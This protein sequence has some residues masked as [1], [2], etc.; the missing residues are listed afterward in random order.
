MGR[1]ASGGGG[2][3]DHIQLDNREVAEQHPTGAITNLDTQLAVIDTKLDKITGFEDRDS[4]RLEF[5]FVTGQ[6]DVVPNNGSFVIWVD[7]TRIEF[8]ET[9]SMVVPKTDLIRT[10]FFDTGGILQST[11]ESVDNESAIQNNTVVC[12]V[13]CNVEDGLYNQ[14]F[15]LRYS[16]T[17][18]QSTRRNFASHHGTHYQTGFEIQ[19]IIADGDGS[20]DTHAQF[21]V[22]DGVVNL[23]DI[24]H[25]SSQS[26]QVLTS[27]AQIL[28]LYYEGTSWKAK[29]IDDFP[30]IYEG[31]VG[32][33][34]GVLMPY[35]TRDIL[36]QGELL[37]PE[38]GAMI[39]VHYFGTTGLDNS[40]IAVMGIREYYN[41]NDA[42][43]GGQNE[44]QM[45]LSVPYFFTYITPIGS[46]VYQTSN[47]Y[48]NTPHARIISTYD[49]ST[50]TDTRKHKE[51]IAGSNS[52]VPS[53][54]DDKFHVYDAATNLTMKMNLENLNQQINSTVSWSPSE[55]DIDFRTVPEYSLTV[56]AST[57]L[58]MFDE[59]SLDING[60]AQKYPATGGEG[61]SEYTTG[62]VTVNSMAYQS[63]GIGVI[64]YNDGTANNVFLKT[65]QAQPD[66]SLLWGSE[67]PVTG[68]NGNVVELNAT[69]IDS[70]YTAFS[71]VTDT[72]YFYTLICT[73]DGSTVS[74]G[75][76]HQVVTNAVSADINY[77]PEQRDLTMAYAQTDGKV[78]NNYTNLSGLSQSNG[79]T[80]DTG[81]TNSVKVLISYNYDDIC[82]Q[83]LDNLDVMKWIECD[84]RGGGAKRYENKTNVQTVATGVVSMAGFEAYNNAMFGQIEDSSGNWQS[85]WASF[86]NGGTLDTPGVYGSALAGRYARIYNSTSG[87]GY[88]MVINNT[89]QV[90]IWEGSANNPSSGFTKIYQSTFTA[91]P[92]T[93]ETMTALLFEAT[94]AA[95]ATGTGVPSTTMF[96]IDSNNT[97]SDNYIGNASSTVNPG[98]DVAILLGLPIIAHTSDYNPGDI[99]YLG[100]YKY[101][102]ISKHQ[103]VVILEEVTPI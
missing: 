51:G 29:A 37:E 90:E 83:S 69:S 52:I 74:H 11:P 67:L 101:Q 60:N 56:K 58:A 71:I 35:N 65:G 77:N 76:L 5:N 57:P 21:S 12:S 10:V 86:S 31:T 70:S 9:Q 99:F 61:T 54:A 45:L 28:I 64:A 13:N 88:N 1:N 42:V 22:A 98:E 79:K 41:L 100:P 49:G 94:H 26:P 66:G 43:N 27:P 103:V 3:S 68:L 25:E 87:I 8:T 6:L 33:Y 80:H 20:L 63:G 95:V 50:Y 7:G 81:L 96:M 23:A 48:T 91:D 55:F 47:S 19:N 34:T 24:Y 93:F 102:V 97:R 53:F 89:D 82:I 38:D 46:V 15:D 14:I 4:I 73:S 92:G 39:N 30:L 59:V 75:G 16:I 32:S 36:G 62:S 17:V 78:I 84:Y 85:Y 44:I 72:N 40:V 18:P 2:T